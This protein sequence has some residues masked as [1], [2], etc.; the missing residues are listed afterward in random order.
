MRVHFVRAAEIEHGFVFERAGR[1]GIDARAATD[2]RALPQASCR[3]RDESVS[4]SPRFQTFHTN[5]PC[6]SSQIA[7][8]TKAGDALRHVHMDVRMRSD[9]AHAPNEAIPAAAGVDAV[10]RQVPM[11]FFLRKL[12]TPLR[13]II[14]SEQ[15]Q[16]RSPHVFNP[17]RMGLDRHAV[18]QRRVARRRRNGSSPRSPPSRAGTRPKASSRSSWQTVGTSMPTSPQRCQD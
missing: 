4:A 16:Q 3:N 7:H 1:A 13:R 6:T 18:C 8:A 12:C 11:K 5:W 9:Q 15:P 2:A 14:F 10:L 17:G